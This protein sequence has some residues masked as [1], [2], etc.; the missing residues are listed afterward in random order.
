MD[1]TLATPLLGGLSPQVFMRRHW[2]K[3]PL[4]IRAADPAAGRALSRG[5]LFELAAKQEV[6]S[7]LIRRGGGAG[8]TLRQGPFARRA[9]PALAEPGW[10]L[11]V[12]GVD[13]HQPAVHPLLA[14]F[15]FLPYARLDDL[16]VS[17]ASDGGGVGPHVDSYDVFLLQLH[18]QRRWRVAPLRDPTL[19]P[20]LPLKIL[21]DFEP[22]DEWLLDA[23]DMLYLPPGWAHDGTAVGECLTASIGFRAP[24]REEFACEIL[25][26]ALD[27][28]D[29]ELRGPL[30]RDPKQPATEEPARLPEALQAFG[31]EAVLRLLSDRS[32]LACAVG[33]VLSEPKPGVWFDPSSDDAQPSADGLQLDHRTRMLYDGRFVFINGDSFRASG[34][35]AR[36][37]RS[38]ANQRRLSGRD[39][40]VLS[41]DARALLEQWQHAGW[42]RFETEG[43]R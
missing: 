5:R 29:P 27:A 10:T 39:I 15:R 19:L 43:R 22:E 13:R 34:R 1:I 4:L 14:G 6:E 16:M 25:Q 40:A 28:E 9:L 35:D 11:L 36:L 7:R 32:S 21:A 23:G 2:Q 42:L 17:Y 12:Q 20:D 3:K 33:E 30:Y 26:R 37:M 38:L 18:G 41:A 24:A 31:I 8:W